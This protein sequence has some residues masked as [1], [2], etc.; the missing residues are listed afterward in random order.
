M[1][2]ISFGGRRDGALYASIEGSKFLLTV[3]NHIVEINNLTVHYIAELCANGW[4]MEKFRR[5]KHRHG[6][7]TIARF[8]GSLRLPASPL[9]TLEEE[10]MWSLHKVDDFALCMC[11]LFAHIIISL[12]DDLLL[13]IQSRHYSVE[14][15]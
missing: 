3:L 9:Y 13:T 15:I 7:K 10:I 6:G 2:I 1:R 14:Y 12:T 11:S 4:G 5:T 8:A